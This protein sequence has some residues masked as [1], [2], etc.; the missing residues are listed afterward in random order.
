MSQYRLPCTKDDCGGSTIVD[1]SQAGLSVPCPKC[2]TSLDVPT[3]RGLSQLERVAT[4]A[5]EE[6]QR[7]WGVPQ[8]LMTVGGVILAGFL[9][10]G[11]WL[12]TVTPP[13]P[14]GGEYK[15]PTPLS[16]DSPFGELYRAWNE[17]QSG[18]R[19]ID[20]FEVREYRRR[21]AARGYWGIASLVVAALGAVVIGVGWGLRK[22]PTPPPARKPPA[23]A[24]TAAR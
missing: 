23:P 4:E 7:K 14:S 8:A 9:V 13:P 19:Y 11:L 20:S 18:L 15:P 3:I 24:A 10:L 21:L 16:V 22:S 17:V 5:P 6:T 1:I 12:L 2:G